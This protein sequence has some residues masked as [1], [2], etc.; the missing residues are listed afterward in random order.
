MNL[1]R[2]VGRRYG[3]FFVTGMALV[4]AAEEAKAGSVATP[5]T[6]ANAAAIQITVDQ[7]RAALGPL[8]S[9]VPGSFMVGRREINWDNLRPSEQAPNSLPADFLVPA[10]WEPEF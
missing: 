7:F 1:R 6:G 8:N 4:A 2:W 9:N 10:Y 5:G 3:W